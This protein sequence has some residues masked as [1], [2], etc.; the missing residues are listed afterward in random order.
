MEVPYVRL[1]PVG[2][3][4]PFRPE[5]GVGE[6]LRRRR[7][8]AAAS[9]MQGAPRCGSQPSALPSRMSPTRWASSELQAAGGGAPAVHDPAW[10]AGVPRDAGTGW[11][12][13]DVRDHYLELLFGVDA[14]ELRSVDHERYLELSRAVSGE[15]MAEVFGEWRR[16]AS[17]CGGGLVLWLA[18]LRPGAGWGVLDH[19]GRPKLAY[20]HLRRA[21]A[22]V[23]AWTTDEGLGGI[24]VHCANDRNSSLRADLRVSLYR[25]GTQRVAS[26]SRAIE[27]AP[28][29]GC[30]IDCEEI[31]G[32]FADASWA[33]RFGPP[34]HDV[35]VASL[36]QPGDPPTPLSQS[37]RFPA[38]RPLREHTPA[39]L[40]LGGTLHERSGGVYELQLHT[41]RL[42][43]GVR[44]HAD[45]FE[46]GDDALTLEPGVP[47]AIPLRR[48]SPDGERA[49]V[50]VALSALNMSGRV[51]VDGPP[52]PSTAPPAA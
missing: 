8:L 50:A 4:L 37:F 9:R 38:G 19:L 22:P 3:V 13:E 42:A 11:D 26:G 30:E 7:L 43:Y 5:R 27:L 40:G 34:G 33:Y 32:H 36:E 28:H 35:V 41:R 48:S 31:L 45:G 51:R 46:A 44:I 21:L 47:R 15:L 18:D 1:R 52:D 17:P 16:R 10:K 6:L 2:G 49:P 25:D 39:E 29:S 12:F 14:R 24:A 20:H 23:A